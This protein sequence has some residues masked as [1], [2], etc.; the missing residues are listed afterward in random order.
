[1][2]NSKYFVVVILTLVG[3]LSAACMVTGVKIL[4]N[5]LNAFII[6]FF[7]CLIGLIILLPIIALK[8]FEALKTKNIKLQIF[9]CSI[10]VISMITWFSA[11]SFM[12]LEKAT[13]LGFTTPLFTTILAVLILKEVIK[14]HRITALLIGLLGTIIIIRPGYIPFDI[15]TML[16][17]SASFSFSIVLI[18]VKKLS[19]YDSSLTI[20]FYHLFFMTPITFIFAIFYWQAINLN[21]IFIFI[22][23]AGAGLIS[24]WC[25]AQAFKLSDTTVVMPLQFT[26][27]IWATLIGY[28]LFTEQ[29]ELWTWIGA[30]IIFTSVI[31]IT[32]RE[33]F[34]KQEK[35][36]TKQVDRAIIN[37]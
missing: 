5:D 10:N 25:L 22:L 13:A 35:T 7:R 33:A 1:L 26:K 37:Q 34:V 12:H 29:P 21:H 31:Y 32:Y 36:S 24:H 17:L 20:I 15:G 8:K 3:T 6:S 23:M 14:I 9:R 28:Y 2:N 4:S 27:L 30:I 11:I 18:M 19:E 16:M